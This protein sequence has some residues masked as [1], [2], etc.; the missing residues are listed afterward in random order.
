VALGVHAGLCL[1]ATPNVAFG[2]DDTA[3]VLERRVKAALL[4]RFLNYVEWPE[5]AQ[6]PAGTPFTIGVVGADA[7][8]AELAD[9]ATGKTVLN[10][11]LVVRPLRAGDA[12]RDV[13]VL[14][15]ARGESAQTAAILRNAP[16]NVLV[17]TEA[18]DGLTQGGVINFI[19][20]DGQ[21]RFD[22][23]LENARRRG[24]RLSARLLSVAH[25]VLG[26]P[27]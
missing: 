22:V 11:P 18:E 12:A 3:G 9:F 17:V 8:A 26:M 23:S 19:L 7:L 15:V 20:F 25:L 16:A 4:Y 5:A 2:A 13:H 27:P 10:H 24:L 14:F 6:P 1:L 21:V